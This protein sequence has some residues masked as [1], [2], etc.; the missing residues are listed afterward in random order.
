MK[1]IRFGSLS[2]GHI[3]FLNKAAVGALKNRSLHLERDIAAIHLA[4]QAF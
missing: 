3:P 1:F 4:L 2:P